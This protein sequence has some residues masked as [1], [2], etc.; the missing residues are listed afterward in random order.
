MEEGRDKVFLG[1]SGLWKGV[2]FAVPKEGL[3]SFRV[4]SCKAYSGGIF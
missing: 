4:G 2:I 3:S 1:M